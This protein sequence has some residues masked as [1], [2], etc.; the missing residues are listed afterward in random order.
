MES[1]KNVTCQR[2]WAASLNSRDRESLSSALLRGRR[3]D[4][5][6][7]VDVFVG[8]SEKRRIGVSF[9]LVA[10]KGHHVPIIPFSIR[11]KHPSPGV[12]L[13]PSSHNILIRIF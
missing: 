5:G 13:R 8:P 3:M 12:M 2:D 7:I 6:R 9:D 10:V 4:K 11:S 1:C